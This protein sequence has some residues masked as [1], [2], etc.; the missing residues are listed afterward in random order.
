[1]LREVTSE[2]G[3]IFYRFP[4]L[5]RFPGVT[6]GI[7]TRHGG[8]SLGPYASLNLSFAVGDQPDRVSEN[9]RRVLKALGLTDLASAN[10]VHGL[11]ESVLRSG[12][13]SPEQEIPEVDILITRQSGLGL[14]IKQ[15]DCQALMLYD[16]ERQVVANVHCGW[17]G[18]VA[19]ILA[20]AVLRLRENFG[21]RPET[22][23]AGIGP[24]LG[25]CCAEF[26]NFRREF[27]ANLWTY[28]VRPTFFDLW[29]LSRDQLLEAGLRPESIEIAGLCTRCR[30]DE[31]YSYR[32]DGVTGRQGAVIALKL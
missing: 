8:V 15:A 26:R 5:A 9:R 6:H 23:W 22:L 21:C 11:Q 20:E 14:L 29:R 3:L 28:Q 12:N 30:A 2:G 18:Q 7:F 25:P 17:R 32:R 16:P 13:P 19:N 1:M 4:G 31:F 10:Q 27:A 24:G